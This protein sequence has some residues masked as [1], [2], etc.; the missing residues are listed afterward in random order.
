LEDT[1]SIVS[2]GSARHNGSRFGFAANRRNGAESRGPLT[3]EGKAVASRNALRH[4]LSRPLSRSIGPVA[5]QIGEEARQ[6]ERDLA[7][8]AAEAHFDLVRLQEQRQIMVAQAI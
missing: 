7:T 4:G 1:V 5:E 6:S 3:A 2:T 8:M